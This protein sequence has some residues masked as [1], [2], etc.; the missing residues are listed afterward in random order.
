MGGEFACVLGDGRVR[1]PLDGR[2]LWI[3]PLLFLIEECSVEDVRFIAG[4]TTFCIWQSANRRILPDAKILFPVV[5]GASG[6]S[7]GPMRIGVPLPLRT[8]TVGGSCCPEA[9]SS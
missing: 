2:L 7:P 6:E 8:V 5:A 3:L 1:R 9:A 4:T